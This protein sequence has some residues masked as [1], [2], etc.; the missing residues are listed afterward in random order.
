MRATVNGSRWGWNEVQTAAKAAYDSDSAP[1]FS[2]LE[3]C[4]LAGQGHES[5]YRSCARYSQSFSR[6]CYGAT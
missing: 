5:L 3:S 2:L 1:V 4:S 6:R